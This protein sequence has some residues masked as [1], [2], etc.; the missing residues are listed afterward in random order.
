[1][2]VDSSTYPLRVQAIHRVVAGLPAG[3]RRLA[4]A[5][6]RLPAAATPGRTS[7]AA[8]A[9]LQAAAGDAPLRGH[10]RTHLPPA[11]GPRRPSRW[12]LPCPPPAPQLAGGGWTPACCT[13]CCSSGVWQVDRRSPRTRYLHDAEALCARRPAVGRH[14]RA[15]ASGDGRTWCSPGGPRRADAAQVDLVRPEAAHRPRPRALL[16]ELDGAPPPAGRPLR[17]R[18]AQR[19]APPPRCGSPARSRRQNRRRSA[20]CTSSTSPGAAAG[21]ASAGRRRRQARSR[22]CRP[23]VPR[24][25]PSRPTGGPRASRSTT[26]RNVHERRR[27]WAARA[28]RLHGQPTHQ[29]H[30]VDVGRRPA[31]TRVAARRAG[32]ARPP[33]LLGRRLPRGRPSSPAPAAGSATGVRDRG[34]ERP[35][36]ELWTAGW[37]TCGSRAAGRR[38]RAAALAVVRCRPPSV[39]GTVLGL[40]EEGVVGHD[41][42][43]CSVEPLV[44]I[45]LARRRRRRRRGRNQLHRLV[46]AAGGQ[47]R[48]GVGVEQPAPTRPAQPGSQLRAL[49]QQA[50]RR[51]AGRCRGGHPRRR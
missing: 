31:L 41:R 3:P 20:P 48:V 4:Q 14:R 34:R 12:R 17:P 7:H 1:M 35:V 11:R 51:P 49:Q 15:D 39:V 24:R 16:D 13:L 22:A 30:L 37:R 6:R 25:A 45:G 8:L 46:L 29:V 43:R 18:P 32:R 2:L 23:S 21:R 42:R 27:R 44:G 47:Q 40:L 9:G 50:R 33:R 38:R 5:S 10:R 36:A 28:G 19:A 26:S